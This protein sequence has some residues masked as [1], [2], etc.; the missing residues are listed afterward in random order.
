[1]HQLRHGEPGVEDGPLELGDVGLGDQLVGDRRH[2]VLPEQLLRGD[3]RAEVAALRAHVAVQQ[4]EPGAGV[5]VGEVLRLAVEPLGDG[6]ELRVGDERDVGGGHHRRDLA[7]LDVRVVGEV[8][9]LHVLGPP[10]LGAG[11]ALRELPLVLEEQVEVAGVPLRRVDRPRALEARGDGVL[12]LALAVLVDPAELAGV[13]RAALR[14]R[15]D[16]RGVAAA[17]RL[18]EG[19]AAG[20][21]RDGLLAVHA[22]PA[23]GDLDVVGGGERVRPAHRALGVDVD[24]PMVTAPRSPSS[25]SSGVSSP[26]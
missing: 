4:L 20:D 1:V 23:E 15:A 17:V 3:V 10:L 22:H 5:L 25:R 7:A 2:R 19:V 13:H 6:A 18:A 14:L 9:G 16:E 24:Q 26:A 21:E 12:R 8:L 11:R